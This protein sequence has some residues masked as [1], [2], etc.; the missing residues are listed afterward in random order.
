MTL[1]GVQNFAQLED[2]F[3]V[4]KAR[5][6]WDLCNTTVYFRAPSGYISEWVQKELGEI[7]HLKFQDQ[8]S[9]GVDAIRDGV[10]FSKPDTREMIVSYSDIQNLNDLEC[11]VSLLGDVPIVKVSL[12]YKDYPVIAEGKIEHTSF[13]YSKI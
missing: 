2:A 3:G 10:N 12:K 8:Y 13:D 9:Y 11:Y 1:I 5:S 6:I 7:H 4:Q